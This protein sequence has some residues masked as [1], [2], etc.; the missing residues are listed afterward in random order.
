MTTYTDIN[1][2]NWEERGRSTPGIQGRLHPEAMRLEGRRQ[3]R[4]VIPGTSGSAARQTLNP[5]H[6]HV[7]DL[8]IFLHA[9][10]RALAA[11]TRFLDAAERGYLGGNQPGV[12]A[13]HAGL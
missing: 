4:L 5:S 10:M 11:K 2:R 6:H 8:D 3:Y 12:D 1:L 13:D 9:V 7:F